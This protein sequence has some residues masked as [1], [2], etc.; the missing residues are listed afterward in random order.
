MSHQ[1]LWHGKTL[2]SGLKSYLSAEPFFGRKSFT[3]LLISNSISSWL[4][5]TLHS[6]Q[7]ASDK[8]LTRSKHTDGQTD[9]QARTEGKTIAQRHENEN[10]F[11]YLPRNWIRIEVKLDL[12]HCRYTCHSLLAW[13]WL[14]FAFNCLPAAATAATAGVVGFGWHIKHFPAIFP[15]PLPSCWKLLV[16]HPSPHSYYR[17]RIWQIEVEIPWLGF[18]SRTQRKNKIGFE[19]F[20]KGKLKEL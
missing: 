12:A 11:T 17:N 20:S 6:S 1:S 18:P 15:T 3:Y 5:F 14:C 8:L 16:R 2:R 13:F 19:E 9:R 7:G 10:I 4:L